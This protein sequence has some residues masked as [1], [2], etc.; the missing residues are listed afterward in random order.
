M[1]HA[2]PRTRTPK[3]GLADSKNS[4]DGRLGFPVVLFVLNDNF[5]LDTDKPSQVERLPER[6]AQR[7]EQ[8]WEIALG[9]K[10]LNDLHTDIGWLA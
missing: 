10:A 8:S 1:G 6:N 5:A 7:S 9:V 4:R 3:A 2:C